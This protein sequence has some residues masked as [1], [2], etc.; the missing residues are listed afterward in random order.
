MPAGRLPA[1]GTFIGGGGG[2]GI[3]NVGGGTGAAP[4]GAAALGTWMIGLLA[5][6]IASIY[7]HA[8]IPT[9]RF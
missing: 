7:V 8:C 9:S 2:G 6:E 3:L 1:N 5:K 4:E